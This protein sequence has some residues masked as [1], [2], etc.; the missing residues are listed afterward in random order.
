[1][2]TYQVF[3][4]D[5]LVADNVTVSEL[6]KHIPAGSVLTSGNKTSVSRNP[7]G[8]VEEST[9]IRAVYKVPS[10]GHVT[11]VQNESQ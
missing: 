10:G 6:H 2:T 4:N 7:D 9:E 1:M 8:G 5:S 11:I 3:I